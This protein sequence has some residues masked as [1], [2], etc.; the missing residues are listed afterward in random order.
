M[1]HPDIHVATESVG[2]RLAQPAGRE[3]VKNITHAIGVASIAAGSL[4]MN[5]CNGKHGQDDPIA[6]VV[7][8]RESERNRETKSETREIDLRKDWEIKAQNWDVYQPKYPPVGGRIDKDSMTI[9]GKDIAVS[10]QE[11]G[12]DGSTVTVSFT[13]AYTQDDLRTSSCLGL[14]LRTVGNAPAHFLHNNHEPADRILILFH[15]H[16]NGVSLDQIIGVKK[17]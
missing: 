4:M 16:V 10:Q 7:G 13:W 8:N 9:G 3:F 14:V 11:Y 15:P 6:D 1:T 17:Y 5:A 12:T 2:S